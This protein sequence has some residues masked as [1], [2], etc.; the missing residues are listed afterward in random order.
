MVTVE[1]VAWTTKITFSTGTTIQG[2]EGGVI[3]LSSSPETPT[4]LF[5]GYDDRLRSSDGRLT[6]AEECE[7]ADYMIAQWM[8]F[9]AARQ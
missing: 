4:E 8:R 5:T 2:G 7:L 1:D 6:P 9:K 3:G